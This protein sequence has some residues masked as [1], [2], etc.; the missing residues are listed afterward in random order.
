M[1]LPLKVGKGVTQ[2][3]V[4]QIWSAEVD[5][6][7]RRLLQSLQKSEAVAAQLLA[8]PSMEKCQVGA[9]QHVVGI[10]SF[11]AS[12]RRPLCSVL[13]QANMT[14]QCHVGV[15]SS[16]SI[17]E[18]V[19]CLCLLP[20]ATGSFRAPIRR[21]L[22]CSDAS[23][24]ASLQVDQEDF[25]AHDNEK[26]ACKSIAATDCHKRA[27]SVKAPTCVQSL[28]DSC[29]I[30]QSTCGVVAGGTCHMNGLRNSSLE[31]G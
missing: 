31:G 6:R 21:V 16:L 11:A 29:L 9:L 2:A 25:M 30:R 4:G 26:E 1:G 20:G 5:R 14:V 10:R 17:L 12:F 8:L 28:Y 3:V 27:V 22:S 19:S 18:L 15:P 23:E 13:S 7:E 24:T